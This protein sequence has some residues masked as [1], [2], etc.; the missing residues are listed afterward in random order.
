MKLKPTEHFELLWKSYGG[1]PL[2]KEHKFHPNR[3][4]RFDYCCHE[5]KL[6]IEIMGGVWTN[7]AHVRG[8]GYERDSEKGCLAALMGWRVINIPGHQV[9]KFVD[10]ILKP[11]PTV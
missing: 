1:F 2:E 5:R 10:M 8:K 4:F 9:A 7:G 11:G 6:A 3:K